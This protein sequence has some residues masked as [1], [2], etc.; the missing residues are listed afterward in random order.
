MEESEIKSWFLLTMKQGKYGSKSAPLETL[1]PG[2][3]GLMNDFTN[4]FSVTVVRFLDE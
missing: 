2:N 1:V 3:K 4:S